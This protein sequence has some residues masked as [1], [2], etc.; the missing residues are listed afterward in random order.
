MINTTNKGP[1]VVGGRPSNS[2]AGR[3]KCNYPSIT[4]SS[5]SSCSNCPSTRRLQLWNRQL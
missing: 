4:N 1:A 5:A 2:S 3:I